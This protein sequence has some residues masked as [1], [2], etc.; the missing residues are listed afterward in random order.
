MCVC[1]YG[2][3][4]IHIFPCSSYYR[5]RNLILL[6]FTLL[7]LT[8][9]YGF[10][11]WKFVGTLSP[12]SLSAPFF[13][14]HVLTVYSCVTFWSF[15]Q[16]V[17]LS[18]HSIGYDLW[19]V[20]SDVTCIIVLG[21]PRPHSCKTTNIIGKCV[22]SPHTHTHTPLSLSMAPLVPETQQCWS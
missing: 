4:H 2:L 5:Y 22:C 6:H 9:N 1:V 13:Q 20:I 15:S 12:A 17:R 21:A 8:D 19:S 18:R 11:S 10:T 14:Q 7:L 3:V 16:Y